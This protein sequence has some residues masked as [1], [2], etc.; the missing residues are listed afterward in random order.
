MARSNDENAQ[1]SAEL[2]L[3]GEQNAWYFVLQK[4]TF[5]FQRLLYTLLN[6]LAAHN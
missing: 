6:A 1:G 3:G 5:P 4:S 2:T